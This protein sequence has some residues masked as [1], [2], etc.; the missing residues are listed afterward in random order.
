MDSN[1]IAMIKALGGGSGGVS[2]WND[3]PAPM[4]TKYLPDGY[5]Y[6]EDGGMVEIL[7][8]TQGE[9]NE[10][11]GAFEIPSTVSFNVGDTYVV[12]WNGTEY[13][14]VAR[15]YNEFDAPAT[16]L[17]CDTF[18]IVAIPSFGVIVAT[19]LDGATELTIS[20]RHDKK[21]IHKLD[22]KFLPEGYPYKELGEYEE[23]SIAKILADE[24]EGY[25]NYAV[26]D[27]FYLNAGQ[28]Y[29]VRCGGTDYT[30]V[31]IDCQSLVGVPCVSLG[32]MSIMDI[33]ENT[34]EP[35][36]IV[37]SGDVPAVEGF[38]GLIMVVGVS[39]EDFAIFGQPTIVHKMSAEYLPGSIYTVVFDIQSENGTNWNTKADKSYS[40]VAAAAK[41]TNT[42]VRAVIRQHLTDID[43]ANDVRLIHYAEMTFMWG[44]INFY[45][46]GD[47]NNQMMV[48][49]KSDGS[50]T[51]T[52]Q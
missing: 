17:S 52:T 11:E 13:V 16:I 4:P 50:I 3:L 9:W 40:E 22:P 44:D 18:R 20:I 26:T 15:E 27:K 37:A 48:T 21:I 7:P 12:N 41:D 47:K 51:V 34:G 6:V 33:G 8:V 39:S 46:M 28:T 25:A 32:N 36:L 35:F 23:I 2:S 24:G 10:A 49:M 45:S 29:K 19:P 5:P 30:V 43:D 1:V 42:F 14:C 38:Y 31:G